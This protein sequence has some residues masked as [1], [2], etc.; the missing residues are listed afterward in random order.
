MRLGHSAYI[1]AIDS[2]ACAWRVFG[3]VDGCVK[4]LP[5]KSQAPNSPHV[6]ADRGKGTSCMERLW[7]SM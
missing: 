2:L 4:S 1:M 3:E 6:L 7:L 5:F